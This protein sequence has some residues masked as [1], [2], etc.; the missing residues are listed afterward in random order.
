MESLPQK[1]TYNT[2][3]DM[4]AFLLRACHDLRASVRAMRAHSE[5]LQR[6][7]SVPARADFDRG[8]DFIIGGAKKLDVLVEAIASY[9]IALLTEPASFQ[10][11]RMDA[12]LRSVVRKLDGELRA[13]Q[14]KVAFTELPAVTGHPDRLMQVLENLIRNAVVHRGEAAPRIEVRADRG[15]EGWIFSVCDNGPGVESFALEKVFL[16]FERLN[17]RAEGCGLG[18]AICRVIVE[19]HGGRIWAEAPPGGGAIF[20]FVLQPVAEV[21]AN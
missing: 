20:R 16:P 17:N 12:L 21:P 8:L 11:V 1:A 5:L 7:R 3:A 9:S 4:S 6:D 14:A 15:A 13:C 10:V 2:D 18:L 19:R